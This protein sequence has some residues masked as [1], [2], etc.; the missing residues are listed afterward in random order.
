MSIRTI[1]FF[2]IALLLAMAPTT[3]AQQVP[4]GT[5]SAEPA[6]ITLSGSGQQI[7]NRFLLEAGLTIF[8]LR[9]SGE[10]HFSATLMDGNGEY[11]SLLANTTGTFDGSTPVGVEVAGEYVVDVSS[12][13]RWVIVAEQPRPTLAPPVPLTL[14]G[15][16]Q[17]AT[18]FLTI[19][20]G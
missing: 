5:V 6:P 8:R 2:V 17:Q 11:L 14:T 7:T 9:N 13:G 18:Q 10:R 3:Q 15:P 19:L 12:S 16:G 20:A 1:A 4:T